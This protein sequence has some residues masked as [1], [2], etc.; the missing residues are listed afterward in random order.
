MALYCSFPNLLVLRFFDLLLSDLL[1][2]DY[3]HIICSA[4]ARAELMNA[5]LNVGEQL[6]VKIG[7]RHMSIA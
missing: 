5:S 1:L 2:L 4:K 3:I 6:V 7:L